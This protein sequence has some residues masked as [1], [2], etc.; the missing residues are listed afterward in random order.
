MNRPYYLLLV[1]GLLTTVPKTPL[2]GQ[3][4]DSVRLQAME[5]A[6]S[7]EAIKKLKVTGWVQAQYQVAE[8]NGAD[9]LD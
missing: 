6:K 9:N 5:V 7:V 3:E 1:S 4:N 2:F 8:S